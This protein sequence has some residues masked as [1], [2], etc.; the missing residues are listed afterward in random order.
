MLTEMTRSERNDYLRDEWLLL[1]N[2]YEDYDNRT[3]G[4]PPIGSCPR[5][6]L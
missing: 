4:E 3:A 6:S 5:K 1:L 2:Q